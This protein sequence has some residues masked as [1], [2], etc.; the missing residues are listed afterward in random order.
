MPEN[1]N[2]IKNSV[3]I[4]QAMLMNSCPLPNEDWS[5]R[6]GKKFRKLVDT[7][8]EFRELVMSAPTHET[9]TRLQELLDKEE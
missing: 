7:V 2:D 3:Y 6:Y 4:I 8:D 9:L 5:D 1:P